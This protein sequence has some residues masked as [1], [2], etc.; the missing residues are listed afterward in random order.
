[1][2]PP[3]T[4]TELP[5]DTLLAYSL[6][7]VPDMIGDTLGGRYRVQGTSGTTVISNPLA[8]G[9][10]LAKIADD[11]NPIPTDRVF[12]GEN[13]FNHAVETANGAIVG[14]NQVTFGFEKTFCDGLWSIELRAPVDS[15]LAD[16]Q[17]QFATMSQNQG[18]CS[19]T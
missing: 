8:A 9:D 3:E 10:R 12:F 13:Y 4:T 1:M 18:T 15:G 11:S 5:S 17:S 14:L 16:A 19:A 6:A 2:P 7:S